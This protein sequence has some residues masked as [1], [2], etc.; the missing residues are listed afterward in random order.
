MKAIQAVRIQNPPPVK[1]DEPFDISPSLEYIVKLGDNIS[2]P[3][4][5]LY[6]KTA[7]L[8]VLVSACRPSDLHRLNA[9]SYR[10]SSSG[11]TF[12]CI[13]PKEYKIAVA[14]S[15]LTSKSRVKQIFINAYPENLQLCPFDAIKV[16]M[17]R[18][19]SWRISES[20]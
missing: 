15:T 19:Q 5:D 4:K 10:Q 1:S 2:M 9:L 11:C 3:I 14:H 12:N 13:D 17:I 6:H 18:T 8:M 20:Q 16:L 7:F